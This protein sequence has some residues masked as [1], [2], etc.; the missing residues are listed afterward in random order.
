MTIVPNQFFP[1]D[2]KPLLVQGAGFQKERREYDVEVS[3]ELE[4]RTKRWR[5]KKYE[6]FLPSVICSAPGATI[7]N[8]EFVSPVALRATISIPKTCPIG[9]YDIVV[10][11]PDGAQIVGSNVLQIQSLPNGQIKCRKCSVLM[12]K[13]VDIPKNAAE[14][15][16]W[17]CPN[18]ACNWHQSITP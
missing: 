2:S 6:T 17:F 13:P 8:I 14:R 4:R 12:P 3:E 11:N 18:P 16:T 7:S 1:G 9:N 10:T 5:E 15:K